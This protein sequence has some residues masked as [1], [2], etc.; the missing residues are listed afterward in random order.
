MCC[1]MNLKRK[2]EEEFNK[3]DNREK[4]IIELKNDGSVHIKKIKL[5][6]YNN[7]TSEKGKY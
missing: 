4:E 6:I 7:L 5:Y 3:M 1:N 2:N